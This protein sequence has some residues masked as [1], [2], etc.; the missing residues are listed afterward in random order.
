VA[1]GYLKRPELTGERFLADPFRAGERIYRTGDLGRWRADGNIEYLGRNDDQVKVRGYRIELGEIEARMI[2]HSGVKEAVIVAKDDEQGGKRL[3]AYWTVSGLQAPNV[4]DLR[5][6]LARALP[7]HMVPSAYVQMDELP[8]TPNGKLDK[9]ALPEPDRN[10]LL[11]RVYEAPRGEIEEALAGIWK[12]LLRVERIGRN[13]NFFELGGDSLIAVRV[14][15]RILT[16]FGVE[17]PPV[18][19]FRSPTLVLLG[20]VVSLAILGEFDASELENVGHELEATSP[21]AAV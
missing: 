7:E 4:E 9:R 11:T 1:R 2:S 18:E 8:L 12:E 17:I 13:D 10:A 21:R 6:Y 19:I 15:S 16:A 20:D 5:A 3:V 14:T